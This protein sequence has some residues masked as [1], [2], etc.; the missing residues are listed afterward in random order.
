[1]EILLQLEHNQLILGSDAFVFLNTEDIVHPEEENSTATIEFKDFRTGG[2]SDDGE[3][4]TAV[5]YRTN[6]VYY[7]ALPA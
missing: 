1:M 2:L 6:K 4:L 5:G 3:R 7:Y